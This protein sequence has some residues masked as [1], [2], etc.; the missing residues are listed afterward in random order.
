MQ[1]SYLCRSEKTTKNDDLKFM[2]CTSGGGTYLSEGAREDWPL[3]LL[4]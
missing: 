2:V 4:F 3:Y 1:I